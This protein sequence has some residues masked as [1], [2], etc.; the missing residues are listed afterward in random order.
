MNDK[1]RQFANECFVIDFEKN[2]YANEYMIERFAEMI[3]QECI[4][5]L[6]PENDLTSLREYIGRIHSMDIIK[7]HF[8]VK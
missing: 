4:N 1:I 8:G 2:I 3:V 5:V 6:N 7:R